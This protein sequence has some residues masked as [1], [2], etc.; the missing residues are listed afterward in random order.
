MPESD[1]WSVY[2]VLAVWLEELK[3][4]GPERQMLQRQSC[5]HCVKHAQLHSDLPQAE[6]EEQQLID[7]HCFLFRLAS[8][9]TAPSPSNPTPT[10]A[11]YHG[12]NAAPTARSAGSLTSFVTCIVLVTS[13]SWASTPSGH[14]G[15]VWVFLAEITAGRVPPWRR[16]WRFCGP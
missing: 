11:A 3:L 10:W 1:A 4:N 12:L 14:R 9:L 8:I 6:E 2:F 15:R 13:Y 7:F 5:W 16:C